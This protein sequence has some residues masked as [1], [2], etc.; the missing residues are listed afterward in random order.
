MLQKSSGVISFPL[1]A[2]RSSISPNSSQV[3]VSPNS[4]ATLARFLRLI[5]WVL[6]SSK[7]SKILPIPSLDSL[8]PSLEVIASRK[9]SNS[10]SLPQFSRSAIIWQIVGFLASNPKDYI[11]AFSSR[12]SIFPE[13]SVS[14]R[15]KASLISSISSSVKPG[16]S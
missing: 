13:P 5:E 1:L 15:L 2:A 9:S 8:S 11:A 14:N 7:R 16:L 10:I 12:G 4:L 6:S 3:I